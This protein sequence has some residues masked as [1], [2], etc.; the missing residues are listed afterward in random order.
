ML[1]ATEKSKQHKWP[2]TSPIFS[3]LFL[4]PR[5]RRQRIQLLV[6]RS[7]TIKPF[8]LLDL[9]EPGRQHS[10][11]IFLPQN[12]PSDPINWQLS[13]AQWWRH[14]QRPLWTFLR[15]MGWWVNTN[16]PVSGVT[17]L[18]FKGLHFFCQEFQMTDC[19]NAQIKTSNKLLMLHHPKSKCSRCDW[20]EATFL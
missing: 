10:L 4:Q 17:G 11:R 7:T 13:R 15:I 1:E 8:Y 9:N 20:L 12:A 2:T 5:T 3:S 19:I 6:G 16:N 18:W 14:A